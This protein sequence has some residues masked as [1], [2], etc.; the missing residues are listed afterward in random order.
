MK[1]SKTTIDVLKNFATINSNLVINP[2]K[3]FATMGV[4]KDVFAEYESDDEFEKKIAIFNLPEL[5]G[6]V[7]SF[8]EPEIDLSDK[9]LEVKEGKQKVKYIFADESVLTVPT[10]SITFPTPDVTFDLTADQLDIIKRMSGILGVEDLSFIGNGK[11]VVARV[12]DVKNKTSNNFDV[13]LG[14]TKDKFNVHLRIERVSK[15]YGGDYV[16]DFSNKGISRFTH[17]GIKLV[18]YVALEA[19]S[20]YE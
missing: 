3:K 6:V 8:K 14:D 9:F 20:S 17:Q 11:K 15:L 10:K 16:V 18:V 2:G 12:H 19:D 13:E 1:V 5:L 4:S 7:G